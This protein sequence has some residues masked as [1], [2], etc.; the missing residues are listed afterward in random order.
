MMAGFAGQSFEG[1][2]QSPYT[3]W[4]DPDSEIFWLAV[5]SGSLTASVL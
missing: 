1:L 5:I 2:V 4:T 3:R